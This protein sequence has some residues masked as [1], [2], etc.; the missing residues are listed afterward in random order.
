MP[1][2]SPC[3]QHVELASTSAVRIT[4]CACGTV[5]L[6]LVAS[7]VT[8]RLS[9]ESL[10]GVSGGLKAAVDRLDEAPQLGSSTIN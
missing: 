6:T 2:S 10:R 9:S 7:G 4:R 1:P 5:H 8:V 3:G